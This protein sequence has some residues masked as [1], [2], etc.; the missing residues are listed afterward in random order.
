MADTSRGSFRTPGMLVTAAAT[1]TICL[2]HAV[3]SRL[4]VSWLPERYPVHFNIA[5]QPD[6]WAGRGGFEWYMLVVLGGL[7]GLGMTLFALNFHKVPLRYVNLP[8]K[9]KLLALP[10]E[11]QA[12]VLRVA[13][14][15]ILLLGTLVVTMFGSIQYV[16][17][18]SA[19]LRGIDALMPVVI[20]CE[21]AALLALVVGSL[22]V[23]RRR[24]RDALGG[25][26]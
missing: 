20:G 11:R 18:R 16:M 22:L 17:Y 7:V 13:A 9:E 19:V 8:G 15:M 1:F 6:R 4:A 2:G 26:S 25:P 12:P 3:F 10:P 5:G 24:L 14:W 21:L 23:L